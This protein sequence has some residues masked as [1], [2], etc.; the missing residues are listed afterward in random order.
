MLLFCFLMIRRP[1][2][3]TRT[4]PLLPYTTLFRSAEGDRRVGRAE[5]GDADLRQG[6]ADLAGDDAD[7]VQVAHL[8]LVGRHAGGGV[9]LHVL[10]GAIALA[11][12]ELQ[13]GGGDV[14][15]LVDE[16]LGVVAERLEAGHQP[17]P[18]PGQ[19]V[20]VIRL[21]GL[22]HHQ[23]REAAGFG[24]REA[25]AFALDEAT[26]EAEAAVGGAGHPLRSEEHTSETPVTNA[27][28]V[29]RLL[30]EKKNTL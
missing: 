25:G 12:G 24:R 11:Q 4:D 15:L 8:A 2:R 27:Q 18:A 10:D 22:S 29:C 28:L 20:P 7:G 26:A 9:A 14:V 30:L 21:W 16:V 19:E 23:G 3:S 17:E 5:G 6:P 13:V 1:P